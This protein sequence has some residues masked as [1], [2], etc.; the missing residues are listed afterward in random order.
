[1][2]GVHASLLQWVMG[3]IFLLSAMGVVLFDKPMYASLSFLLSLIFLAAFDLQLHAEFI[4]LM[5][6]LV[7]AGAILVIFVFVVV[8]FQDVY[9]QL[10]QFKAK[11]APLFLTVT[12]VLF[13]SILP[14]FV[15]RFFPLTQSVKDLP[16][17]FGS[18]QAIG[19]A[20]YLDFFIPFESIVLLFLVAVVGALYIAKKEG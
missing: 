6:I 18:A 8:L 15:A 14:F 12:G 5:Q 17:G 16:E 13:I 3:A 2:A 11:S 20:L 19:Q 7:Y 4:A 10:A 9:Q 1:M